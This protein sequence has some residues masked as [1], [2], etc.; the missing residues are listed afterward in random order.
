MNTTRLDEYLNLARKHIKLEDDGKYSMS[1]HHIELFDAMQELILIELDFNNKYDLSLRGVFKEKLIAGMRDGKKIDWDVFKIDVEKHIKEVE[2]KDY[3]LGLGVPIKYQSKGALPFRRISFDETSISVITFAQFRDTFGFTEVIEHYR[4]QHDKSKAMSAIAGFTFF[5]VSVKAMHERHALEIFNRNFGYIKA[6]INSSNYWGTYTSHLFGGIKPHVALMD[7]DIYIL[8]DVTNNKSEPCHDFYPQYLLQP[9][10][11]LTRDIKK[12]GL[13]KKIIKIL[14][15]SVAKRNALERILLNCVN[16]Y[17]SALS[18][19]NRKDA[20]LNYWRILEYATNSS[21]RKNDE[22][23]GLIT[24]YF[25]RNREMQLVSKILVKARNDLVHRGEFFEYSDSAVNW[26]KEYA[27]ASIN[28]LF[29]L[30][31]RGYKSIEDLNIFYS[32]YPNSNKDAALK[33]KVLK[34][35][36]YS[37][38]KVDQD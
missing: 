13:Y 28:L 7:A 20:F 24:P 21:E 10:G 35:L 25:V 26:I 2:Y 38:S 4:R 3:L 6:L 9:E 8:K 32:I 18:A 17:D 5:K 19:R 23:V 31:N 27:E 15:K 1:D 30:L 34:Q 11:K 29:W 14:R 22:T 33:Q 12:V 37:R 36:T 16:S